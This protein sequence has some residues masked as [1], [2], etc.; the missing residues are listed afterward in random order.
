MLAPP[1]LTGAQSCRL[2]LRVRRRAR[3]R[4]WHDIPAFAVGRMIDVIP[5]AASLGWDEVR[6]GRAIARGR[7]VVGTETERGADNAAR[8]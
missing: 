5:P 1:G 2:S 8:N 4:Q 6:L 3:T 7:G